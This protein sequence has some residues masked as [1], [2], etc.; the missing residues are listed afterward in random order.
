MKRI[1]DF[2]ATNI[3]WFLGIAV[4]IMILKDC[5][6]T[7]INGRLVRQNANL[8]SQID[9]I[10]HLIPVR[11]ELDLYYERQMYDFLKMS[12]YD[13]NTVVRTTQRPDD[14][15]KKYDDK[16]REIDEK[17]KKLH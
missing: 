7:G 17:L 11:Q 5:R 2:L 13:W 10:K 16:I 4:F 15:L 1:I 3:K 9:S 14:I 6:Q 12:L 8:I